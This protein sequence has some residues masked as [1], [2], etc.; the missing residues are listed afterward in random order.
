MGEEDAG[1]EQDEAK[2]VCLLQ[3]RS[4][5]LF[6]SAELSTRFARPRFAGPAPFCG[7]IA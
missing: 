1:I 2:S 7:A 6:F 5:H 3:V 4:T